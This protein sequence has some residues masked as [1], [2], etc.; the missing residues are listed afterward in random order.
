MNAWKEACGGPPPSSLVIP[1]GTYFANPPVNLNGPSVHARVRLKSRPLEPPSRPHLSLQ[2]S[3][4]VD[5][6]S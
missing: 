1:P 5:G 4:P 3:K 6:S 2:S